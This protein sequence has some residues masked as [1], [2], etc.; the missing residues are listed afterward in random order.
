M[1]Y[2]DLTERNSTDVL[3]YIKSGSCVVL[4]YLDGCIHCEM[5]MPVWKKVCKFYTDKGYILVSVEHSDSTLLPSNMQNVRGFP[6]LRAYNKAKPVEEF[7][8]SRTFD[9]VSQFIETYGKVEVPPASSKPKAKPK[10][11]PEA[12]PKAKSEPKPKKPKA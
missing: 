12:K 5:F 7:N 11:K 10:A 9:A 3:P 1:P 4:H 2:F 6:T 8:D